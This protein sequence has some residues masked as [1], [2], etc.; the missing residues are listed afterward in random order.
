MKNISELYPRAVAL[1]EAREA[2]RS[3]KQQFLR[4]TILGSFDKERWE[5]LAFCAEEKLIPKPEGFWT[6]KCPYCGVE[7]IKVVKWLVNAPPA[8]EI[9][10]YNYYSCNKCGYEY[11]EVTV[12]D[13]PYYDGWTPMDWSSEKKA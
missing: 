10:D 12:F 3:A 7:L 1:K 8:C 6:W 2:G 9:W 5:K 4:D 11:A 13:Y